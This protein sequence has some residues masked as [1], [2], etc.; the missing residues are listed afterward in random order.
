MILKKRIISGAVAVVLLIIVL[1]LNKTFVF[2]LCI[3]L[4][5]AVAVL[6]L[7]RADKCIK[8]IFSTAAA[9]IC[10]VSVPLFRFFGLF[11]WDTFITVFAVMIIF[12][13]FIIN[14]KERTFHQTAYILAATVFITYSMNLLVSLLLIS[15]KFGI[16]YV[17][18]ALC[19][20][21]I[22]DTGAYFT[23]TFLGKHKLCPNISPK[24]TVEGFLGGIVA[25]I[26]IMILVSVIYGL[27]A[28]VHVNYIWLVFTAAVCSVS[29]VL[30]DLSAS[31]IKRQRNIKDFGNIMP[32]HGGVMDRFDSIMFTVPVFFACVSA[33]SIYSL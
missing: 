11:G 31:L 13:D 27:I 24:K 16:V 14:H 28:D 21:W 20:A 6:E 29:G 18:L 32:G 4:I 25:D 26:I 8:Y 23:G 2:P 9:C 33:I 15:D 7:L 19:A 12:F 3:G 10:A 5:S 30:G 22:S 17:I 1:I